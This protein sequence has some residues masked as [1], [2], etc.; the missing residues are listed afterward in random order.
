MRCGSKVVDEPKTKKIIRRG[1]K[2]DMPNKMQDTDLYTT[3]TV[4]KLM[5][6]HKKTRVVSRDDPGG[7][8]GFGTG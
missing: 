2:V 4:V 5:S 3:K 7:F 1:S 8:P 6:Q